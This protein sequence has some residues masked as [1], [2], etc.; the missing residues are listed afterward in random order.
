MGLI[1]RDQVIPDKKCVK[2]FCSVH[3]PHCA[4][5]KNES[6]RICPSLHKTMMAKTNPITNKLVSLP[7]EN[8]EFGYHY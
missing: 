1:C 2:V 8:G 6:C 5:A 7:E 4:S 3:L